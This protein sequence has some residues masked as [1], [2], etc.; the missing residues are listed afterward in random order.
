MKDANIT[1]K[2]SEA[3]KEKIKAISQA[4]DIPMS[5][6]IREVLKDYIYKMEEQK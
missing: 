3:E 1:F 2:L 5:Q 4:K 6:L